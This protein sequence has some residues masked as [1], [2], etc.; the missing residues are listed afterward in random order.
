MTSD[1]VQVQRP[2]RHEADLERRGAKSAVLAPTQVSS[3]EPRKSNDRL[4][5]LVKATRANGHAVARRSRAQ[6]GFVDRTGRLVANETGDELTVVQHRETR[7][8][9]RDASIA[10]RRSIDGIDDDGDVAVTRD[11]GLFRDHAVPRASQHAKRDVVGHEIEVVL[12]WTLARE[13][14]VSS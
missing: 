14:V 13:P 8:V 9:E 11:A 3:G 6:F 4:G 2:V 1:G 5:E 7:R 12:S 10:V